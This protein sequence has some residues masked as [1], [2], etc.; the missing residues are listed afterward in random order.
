MGIGKPALVAGITP[1]VSSTAVEPLTAGDIVILEIS[2]ATRAPPCDRHRLR[3]LPPYSPDLNPI[4][5]VFAKLKASLR[6]K[7]ERRGH[8]F[9]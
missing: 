4:E 7:V 8:R 6:H 3:F 5:Q 1:P 2:A 9:G